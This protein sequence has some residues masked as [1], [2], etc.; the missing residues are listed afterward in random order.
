MIRKLELQTSKTKKSKQKW[1]EAGYEL[2]CEEGHEGIQIERLSR[3]TGLNKSG[4]Y[5]YFGDFDRYFEALMREH[6]R[7]VDQMAVALPTLGSYDPE[8]LN[9]IVANKSTFCFHIQLVRNRRIKLFLETHNLVNSKIDK[10][11]RILFGRELGLTEVA[12]ERY[13]DMVRDLF[14]TRADFK[15]LNYE[16][17]HSLFNEVKEIAQLINGNR[18]QQAEGQPDQFPEPS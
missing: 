11:A 14:F 18:G 12:A 17:L 5:H 9:L 3:I 1:I 15:N 16:F 8:F 13:H 7:M 2:F 4:F 6:I 10:N